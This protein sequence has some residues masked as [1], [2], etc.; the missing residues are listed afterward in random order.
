MDVLHIR[1][2]TLTIARSLRTSIIMLSKVFI[3]FSITL[4]T[5]ATPAASQCSPKCC[6]TITTADDPAASELISKF[7]IDLKD[8]NVPIGLSCGPLI[9]GGI[10][11]P[12][13][14]AGVVCCDSIHGG[15]FIGHPH[16]RLLSLTVGFSR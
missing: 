5:V 9:A 15:A 1:F 11:G 6:K 3:A 4:L 13:T 2:F 12:Q 8:A 16:C 7:D 14:C 10:R